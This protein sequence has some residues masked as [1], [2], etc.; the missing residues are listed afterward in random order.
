M[1]PQAVI[2]M[3]QP[4]GDL[5]KGIEIMPST[6]KK[7]RVLHMHDQQTTDYMRLMMEAGMDLPMGED[8]AAP[9]ITQV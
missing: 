2:E 6:D 5:M 7:P 3:E 9:L 1:I 4:T 8:R